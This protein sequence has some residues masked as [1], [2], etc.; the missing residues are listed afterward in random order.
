MK[1][2]RGEGWCWVPP[3]DWIEKELQYWMPALAGSLSY[4][5]GPYELVID[6]GLVVLVIA[7]M[8]HDF[9]SDRCDIAELE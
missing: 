5:S 7:A 2:R 9:L 6:I 8:Y 1:R 4:V 3:W